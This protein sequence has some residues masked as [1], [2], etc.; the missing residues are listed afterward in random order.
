MATSDA[1]SN[2][3]RR[4]DN[5]TH[6][7]M[8]DINSDGLTDRIIDGAYISPKPYSAFYVQLNNGES[9]DKIIEWSPILN[10]NGDICNH[11]Q[12]IFPEFIILF[13]E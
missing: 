12:N 9:F 8:I 2:I 3:R 11:I 13:V 5:C 6:I 4:N 10:E 7:T 1:Y